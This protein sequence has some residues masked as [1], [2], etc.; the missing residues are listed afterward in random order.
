MDGKILSMLC[1]A[2]PADSCVFS[3]LTTVR[4]PLLLWNVITVVTYSV[5]YCS[6]STFVSWEFLIN[7]SML[8][9]AVTS[10]NEIFHSKNCFVFM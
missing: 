7:V 1:I 3:S 5:T 9:M 4:D 6:F 10:I 8:C 2:P